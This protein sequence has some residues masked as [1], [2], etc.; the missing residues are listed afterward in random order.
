MK[1]F[2]DYSDVK[3]LEILGKEKTELAMTFNAGQAEALQ[4]VYKGKPLTEDEINLAK[5]FTQ[6]SNARALKVLG[7]EQAE[8]ALSLNKDAAS[9]LAVICRKEHGNYREASQADIDLAKTFTDRG[10]SFALEV[11]G[12]KKADTALTLKDAQGYALY[13]MC[14]GMAP[15]EASEEDIENARKFTDYGQANAISP[16]NNTDIALT[17]LGDAGNALEALWSQAG[18]YSAVEEDSDIELARKFKLDTQVEAIRMLPSP[19]DALKVITNK[20]LEKL[21]EFGPSELEKALEE[22]KKEVESVNYDKKIEELQKFVVESQTEFAKNYANIK[23]YYL[24]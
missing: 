15:R 12:V 8:L 11:L 14:R 17:L 22:G 1:Q 6:H 4:A 13:R 7:V 18:N 9:A 10:Q 21:Q 16:T 3:T 2:N 20:Q 24:R 23:I 19:T 5:K